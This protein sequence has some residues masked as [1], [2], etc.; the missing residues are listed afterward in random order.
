MGIEALPTDNEPLAGL[1]VTFI[2]HY[3][4]LYGA[5]LSLLNLLEG[6]SGYGVVPHVVC[7]EG[8]ELLSALGARGVPAAIV[9]FEWWVSP[10]RSGG[11]LRACIFS[12]TSTCI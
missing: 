10:H 4:E 11:A 3:T 6:L 9:P 7:P 8:G 1:R 2:T 5:N 12:K